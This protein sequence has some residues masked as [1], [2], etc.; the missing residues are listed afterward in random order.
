MPASDLVYVIIGERNSW[1]SKESSF[2]SSEDEIE[3]RGRTIEKQAEVPE[4]SS[5]RR[6]QDV[7][8][9]SGRWC[10]RTAWAKGS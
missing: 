9:R 7:C 6:M 1:L 3:W 4:K 10:G 8:T 5:V 2:G